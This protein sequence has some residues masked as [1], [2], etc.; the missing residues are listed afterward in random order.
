MAISLSHQ[1]QMIDMSVT[2]SVTP[3][4]YNLSSQSDADH[5]AFAVLATSVGQMI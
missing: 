5:E 3:A 4:P 1:S 2:V